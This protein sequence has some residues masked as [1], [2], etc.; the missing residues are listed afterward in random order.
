MYKCRNIPDIS[1]HIVESWVQKGFTEIP[2][3]KRKIKEPQK[4]NE[5][6]QKAGE[7]VCLKIFQVSYLN[8]I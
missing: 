3:F 4:A 5:L 8:R 6:I 1:V 2:I 7:W